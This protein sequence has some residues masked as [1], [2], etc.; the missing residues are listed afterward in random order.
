MFVIEDTTMSRPVFQALR[1]EMMRRNDFSVKFK[2]EKPGTRQSKRDRIQSVLAQ[3]FSVGQIHIKKEHYDLH[4]E[5][6][7]FGPRMSHDDTIDALA[8]ACLYAYPDDNIKVSK[9]GSYYKKTPVPKSW[10]VA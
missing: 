9:E 3:R 8:Y 1:S 6:I 5:I 7:T 2:E 4:H 10:I